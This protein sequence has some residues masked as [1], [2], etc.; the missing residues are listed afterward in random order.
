MTAAI[1]KNTIV[2]LAK[3]GTIERSTVMVSLKA[4]EKHF[5]PHKGC[6]VISASGFAF[7]NRW[8]GVGFVAPDTLID[9]DGKTVGNPDVKRDRGNI[10]HTRVRRVGIGR[11]PSGNLRAIDLTLSYDVEAYFY[12]DIYS[13]Y[14]SKKNTWGKVL[15]SAAAEKLI[16]EHDDWAIAYIGPG[17]ALAYLVT[18]SCVRDKIKENRQRA[19]F[20]DRLA[21]SIC[22]RNILKRYFG[23]STIENDNRSN[24]IPV[25]CWTQ[26]DLDWSKIIKAVNKTGTATLD[27]DGET[28]EVE[29]EH[30]IASQDDIQAADESEV[31]I[32]PQADELRDRTVKS[33][34]QLRSQIRILVKSIG[35]ERAL[36]KSQQVTQIKSLAELAGCEDTEK[37][38]RILNALSQQDESRA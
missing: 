11:T 25:V 31:D 10:R 37:L 8:A 29:Y 38:C 2:R 4:D 34:E 15:N 16:A 30:D 17:L 23:L 22:E 1:H 24:T 33:A 7:L 28:V 6:K 3:S 36:A 14:Q 35:Q 12:N 27:L 9:S 5:Y 32:T 13:E 26:K 20:G 21:T 19:L 18:E